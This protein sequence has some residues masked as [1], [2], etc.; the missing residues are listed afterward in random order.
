MCKNPDTSFK[1][2]PPNHEAF[3]VTSMLVLCVFT[4]QRGVRIRPS[5][6]G[7]VNRGVRQRSSLWKTLRR[8]YDSVIFHCFRPSSGHMVFLET[9]IWYRV[10]SLSLSLSLNPLPRS[11][12]SHL[13]P[14]PCVRARPLAQHR[15]PWHRRGCWLNLRERCLPIKKSQTLPVSLF[16]SSRFISAHPEFFREKKL[17]KLPVA[18]NCVSVYRYLSLCWT[19][20]SQ[21]VY[22]W[23]LRI[24]LWCSSCSSDEIWRRYEAA[25]CSLEIRAFS[26]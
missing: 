8:R 20:H 4:L 3:F 21:R 7:S 6:S 1:I 9:V 24:R 10:Y 13:P 26:E 22:F 19:L 15:W 23:R 25:G 2:T 14:R 11:S 12:H 18:A 5:W 16:A 17:W